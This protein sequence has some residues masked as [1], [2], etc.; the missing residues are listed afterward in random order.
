MKNLTLDIIGDTG[1]G[2][3]FNSLSD[4]PHET[5][6][7]YHGI[8]DMSKMS[9]LAL[10]SLMF[11]MYVFLKCSPSCSQCMSFW[12]VIHIFPLS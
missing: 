11:P 10:L 5:V 3:N 4:H 7:A 12:R 8:F 2:F 6:E 9:V 1:F